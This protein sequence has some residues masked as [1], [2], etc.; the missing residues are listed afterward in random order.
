MKTSLLQVPARAKSQCAALRR[1]H[2][3]S[4]SAQDDQR[5]LRDHYRNRRDRPVAHRVPAIAAAQVA[6]PEADRIHLSQV[7]NLASLEPCAPDELGRA[8]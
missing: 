3:S 5:L 1:R 4:G 2:F 8:W 7:S 6:K